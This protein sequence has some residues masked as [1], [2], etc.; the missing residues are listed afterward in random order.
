SALTAPAPRPGHARLDVCVLVL[1]S[2]YQQCTLPSSPPRR[3]ADLDNSDFAIGDNTGTGPPDLFCL[4]KPGART[5]N[6]R[7]EVQVL[8]GA[9]NY[10]QLIL[11]TSTPLDRAP[12]ATSDF[13]IGDDTATRPPDLFCLKN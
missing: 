7:L 11:R 4:K 6:G 13:A 2:H 5:R 8:S 12:A 3:P 10:Q 1:A 9:S